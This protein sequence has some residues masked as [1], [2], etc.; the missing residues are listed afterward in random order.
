[1]PS[2]KISIGATLTEFDRKISDAA[3]KL[4]SA[5]GRGKRFIGERMFEPILAMLGTGAMVALT[6]QVV[7]LGNQIQDAADKTGLTT[8]EFQKLAFAAKRTG[9]DAEN[10]IVAFRQ[11]AQVIED[12]AGGSGVAEK[13]LTDLGLTL[14]MLKGK[15]PMEQFSML[16]DAIMSIGSAQER[17]AKATEIFGRSS[18]WLIPM[19]S[20]YRELGGVLEDVGGIMSDKA[21]RNTNRL[22]DATD[23]LYSALMSGI[24]GSAVVTGL[25]NTTEEMQALLSLQAQA[26]RTGVVE[27]EAPPRPPTLL[28]R[29]AEVIRKDYEQNPASLDTAMEAAYKLRDY[30]MALTA[31]DSAQERTKEAKANW[32]AYKTALIGEVEIIKSILSELS[33]I[34]RLPQKEEFSI[35]ITEGEAEA[36][37]KNA[38]KAKADKIAGKKV[39]KDAE[40]KV[41]LQRQADAEEKVSDAYV[42]QI[43]L[44]DDKIARQELLL[45]GSQR[46]AEIMEQITAAERM[47]E[48]KGGGLSPEMYAGIRERAGR[49]WD[50]QQATQNR[51]PMDDLDKLKEEDRQKEKDDNTEKW[52]AIDANYEKTLAGLNQQIHAAKMIEAGKERQLRIEEAIEEAGGKALTNDQRRAIEASA[53]KAY[54]LQNKQVSPGAIIPE[55]APLSDQFLRIGAKIG[56]MGTG[57]MP[58]R[59]DQIL[60]KQT[61]LLEKTAVAVSNLDR[62][63]PMGG[64]GNSIP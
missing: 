46:E 22:K 57:T 47:A 43:T 3:R 2:L 50:L 62:K 17:S 10:V 64:S 28:E 34:V 30:A 53:G 41:N 37:K 9:G 7:L 52:R 1:M 26:K 48:S 61:P 15:T 40:E 59:L 38:E 45:K 5:F 49:Q 55:M 4:D 54:D 31:S 44:L 33:P 19:M 39:N 20:K 29:G 8:D 23:S 35:P 14:E 60:N 16:A 11:Y 6:K 27:G 56:D 63:T 58:V 12:A 51:S 13:K 32:E 25:A 21:I 36:F 24:A 42:E 18:A